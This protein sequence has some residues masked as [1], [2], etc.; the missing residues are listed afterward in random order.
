VTTPHQRVRLT[1]SLLCSQCTRLI[2]RFL[3]LA[4]TMLLLL[5]SHGEV[6]PTSGMTGY[7]GT[8]ETRKTG[9]LT[10]CLWIW[11]DGKI[12]MS[13][14]QYDPITGSPARTF[15]GSATNKP[16]GLIVGKFPGRGRFRARVNPDG[17]TATGRLTMFH[18]G[19]DHVWFSKRVTVTPL[20]VVSTHTTFDVS[21]GF[22]TSF[23]T[24]NHQT[25]AEDMPFIEWSI[26]T[27]TP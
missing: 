7:S 11:P 6:L 14:E 24:E 23:S 26:R 10:L 2:A 1:T 5:K 9:S 13:L 12:D 16:N 18:R 27:R 19:S 22:Q 3:M 21:F 4:C 8:V 20:P 25:V 15:Y 17:V